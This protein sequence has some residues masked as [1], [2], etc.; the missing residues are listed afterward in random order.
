MPTIITHAIAGSALVS[1]ATR[2]RPGGRPFWALCAL[3]AVLPDA[4]V[5][6]YVFAVP[7]HSLWAHRGISHSLLVAGLVAALVT[8]WARR[9]VPLPALRLWVCLAL[10]MAS[11]GVIDTLTV[12]GEGVALLAPIDATRYLAPWRPMPAS[13]IGLAFF[14]RRGLWTLEAE[15]LWVW[16][17]SAGAVLLVRA[18]ARGRSDHQG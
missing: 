1:V 17:P 5:I 12:G 15:M 9:R 8:V 16:L 13:P 18:A 2:G 7:H 10:A 11:H 6:A 4:D 3:L 14:S